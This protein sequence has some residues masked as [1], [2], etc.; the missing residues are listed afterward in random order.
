M[1]KLFNFVNDLISYKFY[2]CIHNTVG[3][4]VHTYTQL[5]TCTINKHTYQ[6]QY[7]L[8]IY[9]IIDIHYI[10]LRHKMHHINKA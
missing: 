8:N 7:K 4:Y 3:R 6:G 5:H 2:K 10:T 1:A 9:T